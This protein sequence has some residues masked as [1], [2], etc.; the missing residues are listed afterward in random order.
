VTAVAN[1]LTGKIVEGHSYILN[2]LEAEANESKQNR[3]R[4][5]ITTHTQGPVLNDVIPTPLSKVHV[6]IMMMLPLVGNKRL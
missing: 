6:A 1:V 5:C 3:E 4:Q 2:I